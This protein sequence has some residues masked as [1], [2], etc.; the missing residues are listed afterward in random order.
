[1]KD[2]L[3]ILLKEAMANNVVEVTFTKVDGTNRLLKCTLDPEVLP[4]IIELKFE[5]ENLKR[6][7]SENVMCVY[8]TEASS[9]KSF[10]YDSVKQITIVV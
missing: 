3:K 4:P 9:W 6:K 2:S 10:R 8:D 5:E 1:M 7:K